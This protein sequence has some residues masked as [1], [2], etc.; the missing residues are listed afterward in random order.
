MATKL[1]EELTGLL[2]RLY[3]LQEEIG[4]KA[5]TSDDEKRQKAENVSTMGKGKKA[6]AKGSRF[7]ELKSSIISKLKSTHELIEKQAELE[8]GRIRITKGNNPANDGIANKANIREHV[9]EMTEEWRDLDGIYK[10]EARK[11]RSRFTQEELAAQHTLVVSLQQEI[12]KVKEIQSRPFVNGGGRDDVAAALNTK[13][14]AALD[15]SDLM[16]ND[17]E[18]NNEFAFNG[19]TTDSGPMAALSDGQRL[20]IQQIERRDAEFD[21]QIDQIGQGIQDLH[22]I[23]QMQGEEVRRQNVMLDQLGNRIANVHDH[24]TNVNTKMKETLNEVGR[25]SDKICV[26]IMCIIMALGFGA[27]FYQIYRSTQE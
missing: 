26:D 12:E 23:A 15:A 3:T 8:T 14:L 9:R 4:A 27:V 10:K 7:L 17:N 24:V 11:K 6:N 19:G 18:N 20:Q 25:A 21:E 22:E 2:T 16:S 13:A 1:D 5:K